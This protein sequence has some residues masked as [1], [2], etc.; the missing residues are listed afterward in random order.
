MVRLHLCELELRVGG[1][2][3]AADLLDEWAESSERMVWPMYERCR[4]LLAAGRGLPEDAEHWA[5][6]VIARAEETGG[7]GWG[8]ARGAQG[9]WDGAPAVPGAPAGR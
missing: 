6:K 7:T 8:P 3:A 4:A 5:A 1:W 9:A 2:H